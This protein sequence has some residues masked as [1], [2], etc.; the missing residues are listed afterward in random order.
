MTAT[1][2]EIERLSEAVIAAVV[3][4]LAADG[5]GGARVAAWNHGPWLVHR[6][7]GRDGWTLVDQGCHIELT[8]QPTRGH[9]RRLCAALGVTPQAMGD[10][11]C[12]AR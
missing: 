8:D 4:S 5:A 11:T 1:D 10:E 12:R 9:V 7:E 2:A 6:F 3:V